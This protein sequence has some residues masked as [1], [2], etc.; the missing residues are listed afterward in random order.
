MVRGVS[1]VASATSPMRRR[2]GA[3][4][5]S[6][7]RRVYRFLTLTSK[8]RGCDGGAG[9]LPIGRASGHHVVQRLAQCRQV[10]RAVL[11][12]DRP[13]VPLLDGNHQLCFRTVPLL[14]TRS[15]FLHLG[16]WQLVSAGEDCTVVS[17]EQRHVR[18]SHKRAVRAGH[19]SAPSGLWS[20]PCSRATRP[21]Q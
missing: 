13:A 20:V 4:G 15:V 2:G 1:P 9:G 3:A 14:E 16:C 12:Y 5:V 21:T 10:V 18:V 19:S 8:L 6:V 7:T 11:R 17:Q